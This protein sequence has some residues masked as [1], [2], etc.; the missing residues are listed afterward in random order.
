MLAITT[1]AIAITAILA[2]TARTAIA[3]ITIA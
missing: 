2:I 1:I 3:T